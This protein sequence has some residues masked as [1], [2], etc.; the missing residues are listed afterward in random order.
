VKKDIEVCNVC[1]KS[2]STTPFA[3]ESFS[4]RECNNCKYGIVDPIPAAE[5]L[6]ELYN[7]P[8]YFA[9]HMDYDYGQISQQQI[10][11]LIE[12][13]RRLHFSHLASYLKPGQTLLEIGP[14]GGFALKA[15]Q[16]QGIQV[17]GL[18]TSDASCRFAQEKL[19]LNMKNL[20]LE[21]FDTRETFDIVMLNHVL[22]HFTDL[23][24]SMRKLN[25]LCSVN[26][27]LYVRVP[28]HDSY[29]RR[30]FGAA[31]PAYLPFHISYFSEASLRIL[32]RE[33]GFEI[34]EVKKYV[35]E[36]FLQNAPGWVRQIAKRTVARLNFTNQF[37]GRTITVIARKEN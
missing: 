23:Q 3:N 34:L 1:G 10:D 13:S 37:S 26:G 7:S 16:Q 5:Q 19:G 33:H 25:A 14:G 2:G 6:S 24:A 12:Q 20:D 11:T 9:T 36:K 22:E 15:F 17:T 30:K 4:V 31:W 8:L 28:D 21:K 18:E 35:S 29:D 27:L 32:F